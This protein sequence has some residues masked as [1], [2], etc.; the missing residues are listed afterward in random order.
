ML[1]SIP[2][3]GADTKS[4]AKTSARKDSESVGKGLLITSIKLNVGLFNANK[5]S[6][7][8]SSVPY[9]RLCSGPGVVSGAD[10]PHGLE[11]LSG[12]VQGVADD[13][14][15]LVFGRQDNGNH[16]RLGQCDGLRDWA[17]RTDNCNLVIAQKSAGREDAIITGTSFI[18]GPPVLK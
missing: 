13:D 4:I 10:Q 18:V 1:G 2:L 8:Y 12:S 11:A 9:C 5:H 3:I 15:H 6:S 7:I 17:G 16:T 14:W